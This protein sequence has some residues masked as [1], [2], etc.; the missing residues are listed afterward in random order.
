MT[1]SAC[2][3]SRCVVLTP[4]LLVRE[5]KRRG[6]GFK[7][8]EDDIEDAMKKGIGEEEM[9]DR[10]VISYL[11]CYGLGYS[12]CLGTR[13]TTEPSTPFPTASPLF[14]QRESPSPKISS[15]L[16]RWLTSQDLFLFKRFSNLPCCGTRKG[17]AS[18]YPNILLPCNS[19]VAIRSRTLIR[20]CKIMQRTLEKVKESPN[21]LR[22]LYQL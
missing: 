17:H 5:M 22:L 11:R 14:L 19:R 21:Q 18:L 1:D 3:S 4:N 13:G 6:R 7:S 15:L 8:H 2:A 9:S 16:A 12:R 10:S 20:F